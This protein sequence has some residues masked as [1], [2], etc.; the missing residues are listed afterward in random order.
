MKRLALL[1]L[2]FILTAAA[3][4]QEDPLR[5]MY[6]RRALEIL[7]LNQTEVEQVL[8][9]QQE[10]SLETRRLQADRE[11]RKAELARLLLEPEPNM[12]LVERNL[13]DTAEI[14]VQ[15]RLTEIRREVEIR[16]IV[17]TDR[18]A[19]MMQQFRER[20]AQ[21]A[22][23]AQAEAERQLR[24][25]QESLA[26]KQQEINELLQNSRDM[27][28]DEEVRR[29]FQDLARQSQELQRELQREL[30]ERLP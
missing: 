5:P 12:R 3:F 29:L 21:A 16:R 30:R 10:A 15:I 17:G 11:I 8:R 27:I 13:R 28:Q 9:I 14:E 1:T 19:R 22:E 7:G 4:G 18:W 25:L 6:E 20:S 26:Q 23:Q 2:M 24:Q